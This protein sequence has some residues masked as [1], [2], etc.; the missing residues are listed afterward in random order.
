MFDSFGFIS[1][2]QQQRLQLFWSLN[3]SL[4]DAKITSFLA[5]K[6]TIMLFYK[7]LLLWGRKKLFSNFLVIVSQRVNNLAFVSKDQHQLLCGFHLN[8]GTKDVGTIYIS[9]TE[10]VANVDRK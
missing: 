7:A 2:Y 5:M 1:I 3:M 6:I 8:Y 10:N 4:K 9:K